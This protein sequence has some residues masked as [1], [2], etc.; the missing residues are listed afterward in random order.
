M[1]MAGAVGSVDESLLAATGP[2]PL[3]YGSSAQCSVFSVLSFSLAEG[4]RG[5]CRVLHAVQCDGATLSR[6]SM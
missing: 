3:A 6:C 4:D 1:A 2:D 5:V